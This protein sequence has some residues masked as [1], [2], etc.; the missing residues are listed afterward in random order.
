MTE[1]IPG[2]K[3][4]GHFYSPLIDPQAIQAD[5]ARIWPQA[6]AIY[7]IDF[8]D[9]SHH[10][11]LSE[12]FPRM[13]ADYDYPETGPADDA[14]DHYYDAN[15]QFGH[16]DSRSTFCLLRH[17]RPRRIVEVG[18]GYSSLLMQDVNRR[19]LDGACRITC[20]EPFPRPFLRK[21]GFDL[22]EKR[23]QDVPLEYFEALESGDVL[24]IDSSHVCK[25]GS[26]VVYLF[27][28]VLPRLKPG[29]L[30]HVHDIF[31]P[32]DYPPGWVVGLEISWNE[33]YLLQA[34]LIQNRGY[35]VL[36]GSSYAARKFPALSRALMG[37]DVGVGGGS[38]WLQRQPSGWLASQW[39]RLKQAVA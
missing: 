35:R 14:L 8:N 12:V 16:L 3:I 11:L 33:Q 6:P 27:L 39:W 7:G 5:A 1:S 26:D 17:F 24:F 10:R 25:T 19:F 37:P 32:D 38:L 29:V 15:S 34:L 9:A 23:V 28:Q 4:P 21:G 18:S 13:I 22:V 2:H 20:I 31:F 30:I 36:F